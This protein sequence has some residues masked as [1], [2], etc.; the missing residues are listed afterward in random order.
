[1]ILLLTFDHLPEEPAHRIQGDTDLK[2][3][4]LFIVKDLVKDTDE[5][6][7]EEMPRPRSR[8]VSRAGAPV[9]LTLGCAVLLA[10]G[11]VHQPRGPPTLVALGYAWRP[12]HRGMTDD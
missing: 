3:V 4:G 5:Q 10:R 9:S 8:R 2:F 7:G 12:D 11:C 1:M 6:A